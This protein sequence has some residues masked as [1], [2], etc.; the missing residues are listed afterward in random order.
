MVPVWNSHDKKMV[1]TTKYGA[2]R[3][4]PLVSFL[5]AINVNIECHYFVQLVRISI[6]L[7]VKIE[8]NKSQQHKNYYKKNYLS[9]IICVRVYNTVLLLRCNI[10]F[11]QSLF[12]CASE[13][14][15]QLFSIS[16][17]I[18]CV[19][20]AFTYKLIFATTKQWL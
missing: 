5:L 10:Y 11:V 14:E 16:Q 20:I 17:L 9:F 12:Y 6:L 1:W 8:R 15:L 18:Y 3:A 7:P 4:N 19:H 2:F 13:Y